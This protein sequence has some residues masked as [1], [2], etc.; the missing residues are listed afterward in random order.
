MNE[1]NTVW[2]L[3]E[4]AQA[5]LE[6]HYLADAIE[7]MKKALAITQTL[8]LTTVEPLNLPPMFADTHSSR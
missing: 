1:V 4:R 3:L 7:T 2:E 8:D 5:Q 6:A